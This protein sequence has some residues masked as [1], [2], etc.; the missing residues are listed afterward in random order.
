MPPQCLNDLTYSDVIKHLQSHYEPQVN[1]TAASYRFFTRTQ[2]EG[3]RLRDFV[4]ALRRMAEDCNFGDMW[5]RMLRDRIVCGVR[6]DDVRRL[7]LTR[8]SLTLKEAEDF[9]MAAEAA[10]ENAQHM[11]PL[12]SP[13]ADTTNFVRPGLSRSKSKKA[14][15]LPRD[16]HRPCTRCGAS[17]HQADDCRHLQTVCHRC[18]KR[19]HLARVCRAS[20]EDTNQRQQA[21]ALLQDAQESSEDCEALYTLTAHQVMDSAHVKPILRQISWNGVPP[22][23]LVDTG[24]PVSV[25]PRSVFER[26][27]GEWPRLQATT[28][29]LSCFKAPLPINGKLQLNATMS[30]ATIQAELFVIDCPGPMLCGRDTIRS[31]N[32][33]GVPVLT[34]NE[35]ACVQAENADRMVETM[36]S[37]YSDVFPPG[38]GLLRGPPVHLTVKEGA[39]PRFCKARTV[40]YALKQ[41]V[42][43]EL[44]RLVNEGALSPVNRPNGPHPWCP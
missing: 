22:T 15:G 11:Q 32:T 9:V 30:D 25:I 3:E 16:E 21:N 33:A 8:G 24:S 13:V 5:H 12:P 23:M 19:S 14:S 18:R 6:D 34:G 2:A 28:M 27:Q 26:H 7:L 31:F 40:P 41:M 10:T 38:L 39:R 37:K 36:L 17:S 4:A 1:E 29:K 43:A 20:D 44:D 42:S 35:V